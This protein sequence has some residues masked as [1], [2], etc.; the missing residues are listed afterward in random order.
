MYILLSGHLRVAYALGGHDLVPYPSCLRLE[1]FFFFCSPR[2]SSLRYSPCGIIFRGICFLSCLFSCSFAFFSLV[3]FVAL[4]FS[5]RLFPTEGALGCWHLYICC[6]CRMQYDGMSCMVFHCLL[7][8][9]ITLYCSTS[10]SAV[11]ISYY[12]VCIDHS[13]ARISLL[14]YDQE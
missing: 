4:R 2:R 11:C 8:C 10:I 7:L 3:E 9:R 1:F 14:L 12:S 5:S 13:R 6:V